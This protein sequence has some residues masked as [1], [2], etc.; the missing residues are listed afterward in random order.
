MTV[1]AITTYSLH[2]TLLQERALRKHIR[3]ALAVMLPLYGLGWKN[4]TGE[5]LKSPK[6]EGEKLAK[7]SIAPAGQVW[8]TEKTPE[9]DRLRRPNEV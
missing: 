7:M 3:S 1:A 9:I 2:Q 6:N 8:Y 4:A 5:L